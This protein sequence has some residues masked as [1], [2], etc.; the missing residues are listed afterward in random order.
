MK[1]AS[2]GSTTSSPKIESVRL[3]LTTAPDGKGAVA[4]VPKGKAA[5][6]AKPKAKAN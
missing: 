3:G 2:T 5:P 4:A 6:A 1:I